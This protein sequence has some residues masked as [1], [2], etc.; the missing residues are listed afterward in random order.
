MDI[1]QRDALF[2]KIRKNK[3]LYTQF[4]DKSKKLD[5]EYQDNFPEN[6]TECTRIKYNNDYA[7][8]VR[9]LF[10][11]KEKLDLEWVELNKEL[12]NFLKN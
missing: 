1:S 9:I 5:D 6:E 4:L 11:E 7:E 10:A 2:E 12:K 3:E 8:K